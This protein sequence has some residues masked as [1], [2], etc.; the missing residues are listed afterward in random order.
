M[1]PIA[2]VTPSQSPKI[3]EVLTERATVGLSP[4]RA[5]DTRKLSRLSVNPSDRS[6]NTGLRDGR[7]VEACDLPRLGRRDRSQMASVARTLLRQREREQRGSAR[8]RERPG[9]EPLGP[10]AVSDGNCDELPS[11]DAVA[12]RARVV[13]AAAR[14]LEQQLSA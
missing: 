13:P 12:A 5:I 8:L 3:S 14:V 2:G 6:A 11:V 1:I 9:V 7:W 10:G 4:P